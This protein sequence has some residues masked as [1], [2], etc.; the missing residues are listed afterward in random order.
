MSADIIR[1]LRNFDRNTPF[2][3]DLALEAADEIETLRSAIRTHRRDVW[4]ED[5][6]EHAADVALYTH[7]DSATA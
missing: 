7:L 2:A 1:R 3:K 5:V 6:P 4:G